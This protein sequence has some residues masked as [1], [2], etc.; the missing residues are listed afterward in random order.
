GGGRGARQVAGALAAAGLR[1]GGV[2]GSFLQAFVLETSSR[3]G[4]A[5]ALELSGP[6]PRR[7]ERGRDWIPHGG[8]LGGEVTADVVFVGYG[9]DLPDSGYA[10]YAGVD[11]RGKVALAPA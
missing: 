4:P 6:A 5:S 10:D 9:A 1:P 7:L 11:V 3:G 2:H 8:S